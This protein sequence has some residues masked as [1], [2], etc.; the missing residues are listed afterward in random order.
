MK[1]LN[2]YADGMAYQFEVTSSSTETYFTFT[3]GL[4]LEM[5]MEA[6]LTGDWVECAVSIDGT[7]GEHYDFLSQSIVTF[8]DEGIKT[9][10]SGRKKTELE[11]LQDKYNELLDSVGVGGVTADPIIEE[12]EEF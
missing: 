5:L 9:T 1:E 11:I 12:E 7:E 8:Y 3:D 4:S 10:L 6:V 2:I